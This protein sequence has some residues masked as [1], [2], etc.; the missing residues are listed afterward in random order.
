[1]CCDENNDGDD[2]YVKHDNDD[3]GADDDVAYAVC[4][5]YYFTNTVPSTDGRVITAPSGHE[6]AISLRSWKPPRD[7]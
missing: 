2:D 6:Y 7:F 1:M 4:V 3:G 5:S